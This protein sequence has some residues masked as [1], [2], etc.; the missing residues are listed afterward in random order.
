ME[1]EAIIKLFQSATDAPSCVSTYTEL[2]SD[3]A[4][5]CAWLHSQLESF[6]AQ[7]SKLSDESERKVLAHLFLLSGLA[8]NTA[9]YETLLAIVSCPEFDANVAREDWLYCEL[10]R[11]LGVLAPAN[12]LPALVA[13]V[14]DSATPAALMEQLVMTMVFRWLSEMENDKVFSSSIKELMEKLPPSKVDFETGMA[15]II[16]AI[17][18]GGDAIRNS[19][20]TF[21]HANEA[22]FAEQLPEKNLNNF[23]ALG[24]LR[25]KSMLRGNYMGGYTENVEAEIHKMLNFPPEDRMEAAAPKT[26][27]PIH[28]DHPKIGRNEPCPCGS[29]KKYKNC[30]GR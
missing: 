28:R 30:C 22:V 17:A 26:L 7:P 15:I 23:F 24:R 5:C 20:M 25:I 16:N 12:S 13:K 1:T 27:P 9:D 6:V 4:A 8:N 3:K 18:A 2:L 29:G 19:V 11:L 21:Y 14:V 10:S